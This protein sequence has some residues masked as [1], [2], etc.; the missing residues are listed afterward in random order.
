LAQLADVVGLNGDD[1]SGYDEAG[2]R[3]HL[4]D[5]SLQETA[6]R[7]VVDEPYITFPTSPPIPLSEELAIEAPTLTLLQEPI[8][9]DVARESA[10][11]HTPQRAHR[12]TVICEKQ[13][14]LSHSLT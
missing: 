3:Q 5:F 9:I 2:D 11:D 4:F 13:A 12:L 10:D 6:V 14:V 1:L 7:A 8:G